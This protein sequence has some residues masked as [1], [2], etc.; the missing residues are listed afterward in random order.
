MDFRS[1]PF[2]LFLNWF[3]SRFQNQ[4]KSD[5]RYHKTAKF[6]ALQEI[7][8]QETKVVRVPK[9]IDEG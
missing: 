5:K 3:P 2:S 1:Q 6:D 4:E 8:I 9:E 7:Q